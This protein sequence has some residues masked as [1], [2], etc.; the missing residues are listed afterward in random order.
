MT[1]IPLHPGWN[2]RVVQYKKHINPLHIFPKMHRSIMGKEVLHFVN[3]S[4]LHGLWSSGAVSLLIYIS[5]S[6]HRWSCM[7]LVIPYSA[8]SN[9]N[10]VI[11]W[12]VLTVFMFGENL[13]KVWVRGSCDF[14][15]YKQAPLVV[16]TL[17]SA[18]IVS[19]CILELLGLHKCSG[20]GR[21]GAVELLHHRYVS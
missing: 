19:V 3:F 2:Y 13:D 15:Y 6:R 17:L 11:K 10:L 20:A 18:S 1:S 21:Q 14:G 16:F 7:A 8:R 5:K 9:P 4:L 12:W